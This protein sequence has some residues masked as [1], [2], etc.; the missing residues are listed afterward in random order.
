MLDMQEVNLFLEDK[1]KFLDTINKL[2]EWCL[3]RVEE[4]DDVDET[5]HYQK[6]CDSERARYRDI[7]KCLEQ[8]EKAVENLPPNVFF[9]KTTFEYCNDFFYESIHARN[10]L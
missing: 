10:K 5:A 2:C 9:L 3:K 4:T 6:I 8:L 7:K 1:Y